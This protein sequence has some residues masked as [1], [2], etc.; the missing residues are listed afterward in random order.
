ML[1]LILILPCV[2]RSQPTGS[3]VGG[4]ERRI[5][6]LLAKMTLEEKIGQLTQYSPSVE[7]SGGK[8]ALSTEQVAL[9]QQG[10]VGSYLNVTGAALTRKIQRIA[11]T[12][13]R[14]KIPLI[15]GLDVIHGFR[16]VFPIPL[17]EA[18]TWEPDLIRKAARTAALEATAAG[19]HWTFAPMVDIARDPRWGRIAE[20][21]GED[22][23][24]GSLMAA[25]RVE[26]F[27]GENL[28][29]TTS[30]VACPKHFAAYGGAEGGRDY[31]VVDM[32]ER[33]LR[34]IYL[35]PFESAVRAGAG[36]V[37]CSF[38]E[39]AGSPSTSN[40][41]LLTDI[42]RG[43]W[44]FDGFVV[45]DWGSIGEL[46]SHGVASSLA[47]A[48]SLAI[49]A[50][51]DMDMES[52]AYTGHLA[53]LVKNG[54][55]AQR[56][57]DDAVRR[58]LR[59]KFRLGLFDD[60]YHGCSVE[61][62]QKETLSAAH[63]ALARD[64]A[65]RSIVLLK[66]VSNTLPLGKDS[67]TIAVIGPLAESREDPLG[68]WDAMGQA[69]DVVSVLDGIR[70][71]AGPQATVLY[72]KGCEIDSVATGGFSAAIDAAG[73][74]DAVVLVMGESS[75][76]SGEAA[77]RSSLALPGSQEDLVKAV[78]ATGKPVVVVLL[79]GRPLAIPWIAEHIPAVLDAWF[80]GVET[81]NAVADVIFGVY[82]PS[83]KLPV[84]FPR[85]VGQ[86]PIYYNHKN[87]GRPGDIRE[88]YTSKYIDLPLTPLYPFGYGL[89]YTT[90]ACG[91]PVVTPSEITDSDSVIVAVELTNRGDR[92][93]EEVVQV[94]IRDDVASV[95]RP[96]KELKAFQKVALKPGETRHVSFTIPARALAMYSREM[97]RVVESGSF[98][99]FVGTNSEETQSATFT[100]VGGARTSVPNR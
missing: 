81:G 26:G 87:T 21:S 7:Q 80:P 29:L 1:F 19:I 53:D 49:T 15:F 51:T 63:R 67:R 70:K 62:E 52:K 48:A 16:T 9:V 91:K 28:A 46:Q 88:K 40:R 82:N 100:V 99:V 24:L 33:T 11:V 71:N 17:G 64:V 34:E 77:S 43:E 32:S 69:A 97:K 89:S 68:P 83:G 10:K 76:M 39:I 38:N 79:N 42:L 61:R 37:M 96:V 66:N 84:T 65:R 31:N 12:E 73:R 5:D 74:S 20:G 75:S 14:L 55:V 22:P 60:P 13:S 95:T 85:T 90:F 25:A 98:T 59:I 3:P 72:A 18:S 6:S 94:Y 36:T 35:P 50:G 54:A 2:S 44:G 8:S 58:V 93:G 23:Y 56:T 78:A 4:I 86:V 47:E 41:R 30:M 57:V 45:S 27:Q 92:A